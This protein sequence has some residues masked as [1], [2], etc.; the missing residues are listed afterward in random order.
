MLNVMAL[1]GRTIK[2]LTGHK[3]AICTLAIINDRGRTILASGGD[4]GCSS[5]FLWDTI[6]WE[7]IGRLQHHSTAVT[8]ILD[9]GDS[10][11]MLSGSYDKKINV[12]NYQTPA[13]QFSLPNNK[14]SVFALLANLSKTKLIV[15]IIDTNTNGVSVW[16]IKYAQNRTVQTFTLDRL[17]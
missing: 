8:S 4:Y 2:R 13:L 12:Y 3:S 14:S 5:I 9:L 16:S 10:Q 11:T 6:S 15:G 17:I 7:I 1:G